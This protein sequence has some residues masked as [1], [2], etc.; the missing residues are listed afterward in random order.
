MRAWIRLAVDL[1]TAE[2]L[3]DMQML[4]QRWLGKI[5]IDTGQ[6]Q[7]A[8]AALHSKRLQVNVVGLRRG[9]LLHAIRSFGNRRR[10]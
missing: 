10:A 3:P 2:I 1:R 5:V 8:G 4:S 6:S 7:P 9:L